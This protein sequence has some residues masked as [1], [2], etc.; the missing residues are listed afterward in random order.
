M[1]VEITERN[2]EFLGYALNGLKMLKRLEKAP[3]EMKG[4]FLVSSKRQKRCTKNSQ[5]T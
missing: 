4:L 2:A 1:L 3:D 5:T